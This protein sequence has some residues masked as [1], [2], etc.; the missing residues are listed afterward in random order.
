VL[1]W[2]RSN[3]PSD[4]F[5]CIRALDIHDLDVMERGEQRGI[6]EIESETLA[7]SHYELIFIDV[8]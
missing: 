6:V 8:H 3:K 7:K 4:K 2:S 1:G 5:I